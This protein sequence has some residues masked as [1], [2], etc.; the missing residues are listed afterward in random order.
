MM[1]RQSFL[2]AYQNW[3]TGDMILQAWQHFPMIR[4][5]LK[6]TKAKY[7]FDVATTT[8]PNLETDQSIIDDIEDTYG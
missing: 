7:Q 6:W 5:T 3:N 4:F 1:W 2:T 8:T